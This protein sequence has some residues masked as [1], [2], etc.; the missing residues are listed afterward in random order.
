MLFAQ[1]GKL[2]PRQRANQVQ[3]I[4]QD[5]RPQR[6]VRTGCSRAMEQRGQGVRRKHRSTGEGAGSSSELAVLNRPKQV[7]RSA[8]DVSSHTD[9]K[10]VTQLCELMAKLSLQSPATAHHLAGEVEHAIILPV[11][12]PVTV[13][14]LRVGSLYAESTKPENAKWSGT[15]HQHV[16]A[17]MIR[18]LLA[19]QTSPEADHQLMQL[20]S[21]RMDSFQKLVGLVNTRTARKIRDPKKMKITL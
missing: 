14:T 13:E 15:P 6:I 21:V 11:R 10:T 9:L 8:Q 18:V 5:L 4:P 17:A 19:D 2:T 7:K 12:E 16:R 1:L 20:H 3:K